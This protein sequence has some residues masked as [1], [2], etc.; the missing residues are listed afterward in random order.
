MVKN[1]KH[2]EC[3]GSLLASDHQDTVREY[4]PMFDYYR[5]GSRTVSSYPIPKVKALANLP[6]FVL[7]RYKGPF[8]FVLKQL[9]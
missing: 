9:K 5:E 3:G 8:A 6:I 1:A 2:L 4:P 7:A